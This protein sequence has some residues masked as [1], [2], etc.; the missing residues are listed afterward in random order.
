MLKEIY[1]IAFPVTLISVMLLIGWDSAFAVIKGY[2]PPDESVISPE[3]I[4]DNDRENKVDETNYNDLFGDELV[5]PFE[6][7]LGG[8]QSNEIR[9]II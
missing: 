8:K 2:S 9:D 7:G 1:K 6:P 5:F 4:I 3:Q